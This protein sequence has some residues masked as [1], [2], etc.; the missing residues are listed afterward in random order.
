MT[1]YCGVTNLI[2]SRYRKDGTHEHTIDRTCRHHGRPLRYWR[3]L[4]ASPVPRQT[5]KTLLTHQSR[6]VGLEAWFSYVPFRLPLLL[7]HHI[8]D[9]PRRTEIMDG[10]SNINCQQLD[11]L[12]NWLSNFSVWL[13]SSKPDLHLCIRVEHPILA[14]ENSHATDQ[15]PPQLWGFGP[16]QPCDE[17]YLY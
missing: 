3:R 1:N 10:T 14:Q 2:S 17:S 9:R 5:A 12:R 15:E 16:K 13:H 6:E 8:G 7:S 4:C 11:R